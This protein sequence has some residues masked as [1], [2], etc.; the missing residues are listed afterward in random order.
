LQENVLSKERKSVESKQH[1][2]EETAVTIK[3]EPEKGF[4]KLSSL[5]PGETS[6]FHK[7]KQFKMS[8]D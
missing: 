1:Q 8:S 7:L 5:L 2:E 4:F 6:F 3:I